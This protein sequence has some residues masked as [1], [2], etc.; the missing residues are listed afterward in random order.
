M[1]E[2]VLVFRGED[3]AVAQPETF[4]CCPLGLQFYARDAFPTYRVLDLKVE[5]PADGGGRT[6]FDCSGVVVHSEYDEEREL[7]RTWVVFVD[8]PPEVRQRFDCLA[9][10]GGFLCP[11]CENY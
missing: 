10:K 8:V 11:H 9:R 4:R 5:V 1:V 3:E 2:S 6:P 7:F